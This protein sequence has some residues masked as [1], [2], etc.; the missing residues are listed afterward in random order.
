MLLLLLYS[1]N[2]STRSP[3]FFLFLIVKSSKSIIK[4]VF[5]YVTF[6]IFVITSIKRYLSTEHITSIYVSIYFNDIWNYIMAT[7]FLNRLK[8][9]D[10]LNIMPHLY[11][12]YYRLSIILQHRIGHDYYEANFTWL[13]SVDDSR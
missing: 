4:Y 1:I 10:F 2:W 3:N 13:L 5:H 6:L 11:S 8:R 12:Y 7:T 9:I